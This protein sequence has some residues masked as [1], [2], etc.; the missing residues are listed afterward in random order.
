MHLTT[1]PVYYKSTLVCPIF[2][3]KPYHERTRMAQHN[4]CFLHNNLSPK[5]LATL[6]LI[7]CKYALVSY[8]MKLICRTRQSHFCMQIFTCLLY[9]SDAA[10]E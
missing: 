9:T 2:S 10:D 5:L 7:I 3:A 1:K 8:E 4:S 6:E